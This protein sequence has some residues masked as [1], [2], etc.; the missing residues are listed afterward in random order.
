MHCR[1]GVK[2]ANV[3]FWKENKCTCQIIYRGLIF[4]YLYK[5]LAIKFYKY[6]IKCD[7]LQLKYVAV[8]YEDTFNI[9]WRIHE[10]QNRG[11][12]VPAW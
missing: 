4:A 2:T 9:K 10:F 5:V 6:T 8:S 1:K 7:V 11:R 3:I 12:A